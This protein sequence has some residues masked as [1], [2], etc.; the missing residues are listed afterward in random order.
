MLSPTDPRP[1]AAPR[2]LDL[3]TA[4][5]PGSSRTA[6]TA[7][8]RHAAGDV[9]T[10]GPTVRAPRVDGP[11]ERLARAGVEAL[12][13]AELVAILLG[14]GVPGQPVEVLAARVL[15]ESGGLGGLE[16]SGLGALSDLA[17]IGVGKACRLLAALEVGRRVVATPLVRGEPIASSRDVDRA[18]RARLGHLDHEVFVAIALDAKLRATAEV[19][20]AQGGLTAA[21]VTP[22]DVFRA[23]VREAAAA[24]IF[25]HNHPSGDPSPSPEDMTLTEQL[26]R[27]GA[28]LG[29]RVLDHLVLGREGYFSFLDAGLLTAAEA[30]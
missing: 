3:T 16:R 13:D 12:S 19:R 2:A 9:G 10:C 27:A 5:R 15:A 29:V 25:V 30:A 20:V 18:M 28:V 17:G 6:A 21:H 14:T 22:S 24:V 7:P 11:R 1:R 26:A 8:A 4:T 23:L